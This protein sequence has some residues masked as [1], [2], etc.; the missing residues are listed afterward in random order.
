MAVV[1]LMVTPSSARP[2]GR[3]CSTSST[4][5][6]GPQVNGAD[7]DLVLVLGFVSHLELAGTVLPPGEQGACR[8]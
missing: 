5:S 8:P 2:L 6:P 7:A 1:E 3:P 4:S